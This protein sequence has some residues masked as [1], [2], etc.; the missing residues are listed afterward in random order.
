MQIVVRCHHIALREQIS[1]R[2][3]ED[4]TE[5]VNNVRRDRLRSPGAVVGN[6]LPGDAEVLCQFRI[7]HPPV[8]P[9]FVEF[10]GDC[11][12]FSP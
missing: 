2:N 5:S 8:Q 1:P 4:L 12:F 10:L 3:I 9:Q 11:A 7:F 6:G